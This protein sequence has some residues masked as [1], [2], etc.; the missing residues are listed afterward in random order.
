MD[1]HCS[2][3]E[4]NVLTLEKIKSNEVSVDI[5]LTQDD[6]VI[7]PIPTNPNQIIVFAE[8]IENCLEF[9]LDC[10]KKFFFLLVHISFYDNI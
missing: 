5:P 8:N 6:G 10:D 7:I 3:A 4:K 1:K 9:R 2:V